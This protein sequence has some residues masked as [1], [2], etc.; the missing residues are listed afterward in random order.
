MKPSRETKVS[1]RLVAPYLAYLLYA[2][3]SISMKGGR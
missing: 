2:V 1:I 3:W